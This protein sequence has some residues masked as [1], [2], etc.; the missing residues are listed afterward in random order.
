MWADTDPR[1]L[2]EVMKHLDDRKSIK[3]S[4]TENKTRC[5]RWFFY[6]ERFKYGNK[7]SKEW[8]SQTAVIDCGTHLG[9]L[10]YLGSNGNEQ[11]SN[12]MII[13]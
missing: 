11:V 2:V 7:N 8:T 5:G 6:G 3:I 12:N 4:K 9:D 10:K 13:E 1:W